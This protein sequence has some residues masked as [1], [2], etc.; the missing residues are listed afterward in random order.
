MGITSL[1]C[2]DPMDTIFQTC[3][4]FLYFKTSIFIFLPEVIF[5]AT[6][7]AYKEKL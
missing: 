5:F 7:K 6:I 4:I 2:L 3:N 1:Q